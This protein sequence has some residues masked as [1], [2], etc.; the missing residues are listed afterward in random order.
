MRPSPA[1]ILSWTESSPGLWSRGL[2]ATEEHFVSMG[3]IAKPY[4]REFGFL[5]VMMKIDFG[6]VDPIETARNAW[7]SIRYHQPL[8]ASSLDGP[9]RIYRT[10]SDVE[11]KSWLKE[12]FITYPDRT[13]DQSAE[14]LRLNLRPVKRA[15]LH[16]LPNSREIILHAG[17]DVLDGHAMLI[18]VNTLLKELNTPT[19]NIIFGSEATKLPLP[20][21]LAA[22]V[23]PPTE[24]QKNQV[25]LAL[26]KWFAALPWLSIRAI[27]TD[28]PPGD[29]KAQRQELTE[30][31]T[32]AVIAAAK[33]RG[34]S[35]THV[36][37][38]AAI[39]AIAKLDLEPSDKSYGSC[40]IFSM[41]QQCESRWRESVIPYLAI[42][43]MV[44]KPTNFQDTCA[45]LKAYY[46]DLRADSHNFLSLVEPVFR[47]FASMAS[48]P[49]PPGSN[50]MTSLSSIGRLEPALQSMHGPVKLEDLWLM[51]ET[52]NAAVNSFLWTRQGVLSWQV[53]YNAM[54]Y[55]EETIAKWIA[56][57]RQTLFEGLGIQEP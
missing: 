32:E 26:E 53:V 44:I 12:T 31:E 52:P 42:Y 41:R 39:L 1:N 25:K 54:Y 45:Q 35:P 9:K 43:P 21:C 57:T 3:A 4:G 18:L 23:P 22:N 48:N 13:S 24:K 11:L 33:A 46:T 5:S 34:F 27:N 29:T 49:P 38:A 28:Q 8:L 20:L 56:M 37:E 15:Q 36:V 7:L 6:G 19:R 30:A 55:E 16:V 47:S 40:G 50:R 10:A 17:H 14:Q 2:D 51:Y